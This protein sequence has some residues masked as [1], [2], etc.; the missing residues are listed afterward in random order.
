MK[1]GKCSKCDKP[2]I[3]ST[4]KI[5]KEYISMGIPI[6]G[7]YQNVQATYYLCSNCGFLETYVIEVPAIKKIIKSWEKVR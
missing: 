5:K 7:L 6:G 4:T 3:Y 1:N 2:D